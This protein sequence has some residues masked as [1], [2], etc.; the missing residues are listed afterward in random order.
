MHKKGLPKWM[1]NSR[2]VY[3]RIGLPYDQRIVV[4]NYR[5]ARGG[6]PEQL[7]CIDFG[8]IA[9][10]KID[11]EYMEW[12]NPHAA[13]GPSKIS[14]IEGGQGNGGKAY[15]RQMFDKGHFASIESGKLSVVS[16]LDDE[17]YEL[18]FVPDI[19]TGKD[20]PGDNPLLPG[21]RKSARDWL[22]AFSLPDDH[23]ITI[24]RGLSPKK[25]VE[26]DTLV[27][28]IQQHPQSRQT[29]RTC[30]VSLFIDSEF[31]RDLVVKE[32]ERDPAFPKA[33]EIP[34]PTKIDHNGVGIITCQ[35]PTFP[36]GKLSLKVS[37]AP[38]RGQALQTWNRI[39]FSGDSVRV[40]GYKQVP[41]LALSHPE[42][43]H[44]IYGEC[45]VPLLSDPKENYE[46]MGRGP[47]VDGPLP[48]ALYSFI[49]D[50]VDKVLEQLAKRNAGIVATKK[51]KNLEI[52]NEKLAEWVKNKLSSLKGL[53]QTDGGVGPGKKKRKHPTKQ[54][55]NPPAKI[56]V[57]RPDLTICTNVQ[58]ELRVYGKDTDGKIVPPGKL[59]WRSNN[60]S[61]VQVH[62][63]TGQITGKSSGLASIVAENDVGLLTDPLI[64]NVIEGSKIEIKSQS[65]ARLGSNRRL[66]LLVYVT[67]RTEKVEKDAIVAWRTSDISTVSVG[68]DGVLVGG[69]VGEAEVV[70]YAGAIVSNPLE[71]VVEKGAGGK[72]KGGGHGRPSFLLSGQHEDPFGGSPDTRLQPTDPAVYQRPYKPDYENNVFW[73]NLQ[74]TLAEALLERGEN[75]VQ[76]RTY[77][78]Q[79]IV[80]AYTMIELRNRFED[81]QTLDVDQVLVEIHEIMARLY[82]DARDEIYGILYAENVDIAAL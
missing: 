24:V 69:E 36:Q 29:I 43:A 80:D 50:E 13:P 1:K 45:A 23:N 61:V 73:I 48:D 65:P 27:E 42:F 40:I 16:F 82:R 55:H 10:S 59:T 44:H 70:A 8:G 39:D 66:P 6:R 37:K 41:E 63:E 78:F 52:L 28:E 4:I 31:K 25:P 49:A 33:I 34:V 32:P 79:R 11:T 46:S 14:G 53:E 5:T 81:S 77:H 15:L 9:G 62:P 17:K 74:H 68:Q 21:F 56:Y 47:L 71:V 72:P 51:R 20:N 57:H 7:E 64:V 76:W 60:S 26:I 58:Y 19:A 54:L 22:R 2:E 38:L 35:P 30:R 75:S 3:L 12:A 67:T 18:G